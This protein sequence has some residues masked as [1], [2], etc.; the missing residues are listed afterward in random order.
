M[1]AINPRE[2]APLFTEGLLSR[3]AAPGRT[4]RAPSAP[5]RVLGRT[6]AA[7]AA[8]I[9]EH[10]RRQRVIAELSHLT[11]RELAD[12]GLTRADIAQIFNPEFAARRNAERFG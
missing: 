5:K 6:V 9:R 3:P 4:E 8:A 11:D 10:F 12:I 2:T 1:T 7:V